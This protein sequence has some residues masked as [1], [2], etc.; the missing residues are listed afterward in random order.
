MP[1]FY[2]LF[3]QGDEQIVHF[4]NK[5]NGKFLQ[6]Q[7]LRFPSVYG[8]SY[9]EMKDMNGD[10]RDDIIYTCG[11]NAD[12]STEL[13]PYHG[14][15][16]FLNKGN[17][18]F[19]QQ[20]FFHINGCFKA[21]ARDFDQDGDMDIAAISFFADYEHRPEEGF[22]YLQNKGNLTFAPYSVPAAAS[23]RWLTMEVADMD[24]DG[25][26]DILLGN[27]SAPTFTKPAI[28]WRQQPAFLL[29]K[30]TMLAAKEIQNR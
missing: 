24:K 19:Q 10:G 17:D 15:Y 7:V 11:D 18:E 23:G 8:S 20:F 13:K 1:G 30:N 27:F 28:D 26:P 5:G 29:L 12:Y 2:V 3:A 4:I 22:V 9:F 14:V 16:V 25:K 21:I 6:K